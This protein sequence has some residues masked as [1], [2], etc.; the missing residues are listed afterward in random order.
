MNKKAS[1]ACL[2]A[3]PPPPPLPLPPSPP[4]TVS[5]IPRKRFSSA[6][7]ASASPQI[8]PP[9]TPH[10]TFSAPAPKARAASAASAAAS[11]TISRSISACN[12]CRSRKT[13]C[14][15]LFPSCTAC[16]KANVECIG[17]DAATGREVP[18][19]YV[20]WLE[21]RVKH[22]EEQ[23]QLAGP[24]PLAEEGPLHGDRRQSF[25]EHREEQDGGAG[26]QEDKALRLRP[27]IENLV[28][29]VGLVGVQGTSAPGFLGGSSGIS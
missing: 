4:S 18:R 3:P 11:G 10:A 27:D 8:P 17:I 22:L 6:S 5:S 29:Q 7:S 21:K 13:K 19:S 20:D 26:R 25:V 2:A 15:Q 12:R 9:T 28:D 23:M 1:Q 14:D 24:P 16:T